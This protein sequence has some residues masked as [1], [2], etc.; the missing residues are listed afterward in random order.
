MKLAPLPVVQVL[1]VGRQDQTWAPI[2]R[3]YYEAARVAGDK[4]V[5]LIEAPES[6]HFELI[7]PKSTTWPLVIESLG[8]LMT[9]R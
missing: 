6:G 4:Q 5:T 2:G 7:A 8:S 3:A 9:R 1:L